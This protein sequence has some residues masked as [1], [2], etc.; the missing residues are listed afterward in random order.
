MKLTYDT[1]SMLGS[2]SK[3]DFKVLTGVIIKDTLEVHCR[4]TYLRSTEKGTFIKENKLE[5][6]SEILVDITQTQ[7]WEI[8]YIVPSENE[9]TNIIGMLFK[10]S[11]NYSGYYLVSDADCEKYIKFS[12]LP[13]DFIKLKDKSDVVQ[14][15]MKD[16][17][18]LCSIYFPRGYLT[19]NHKQT[20]PGHSALVGIVL[21]QSLQNPMDMKN[22]AY[23]FTLTEDTISTLTASV[24]KLD[25]SNAS[26]LRKAL[27]DII[28]RKLNIK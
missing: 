16:N 25:N 23:G 13:T 19:L 11:T 10:S 20:Y 21:K 8:V 1:V 7:N 24:D 9:Y 12:T 26:E 14:K 5:A 4:P 18:A 28:A 22:K 6:L 17:D 27:E 3:G 15:L 2:Y